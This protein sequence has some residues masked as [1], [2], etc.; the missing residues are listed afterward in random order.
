MGLPRV[1]AAERAADIPAAVAPAAPTVGRWLARRKGRLI[2]LGLVIVAAVL[3]VFASSAGTR[4]QVVRA[5]RRSLVQRVVATGRVEPKARITIG[6]L[7]AGTVARVGPEE[8]DHVKA[9]ELLVELDAVEARAAVDQ[10]QAG[11]ALAQAR[12]VQ[13]RGTGVKLA[14]ESLRQAELSL[15]NAQQGLKRTES[16]YASGASAEKELDDARHK[17]ELAASQ[18]DSA[19]L[20]AAS[21]SPGGG[22]VLM[23]QANLAQSQAMLAQAK[24]RLEQLRLTAPVDALVLSRQVEKGDMV[25]PGRALYTLAKDGKT[26]L[27]AQPDEKSLAFLATGQSALASADAFP[28]QTFLATVAAIAPAVDP[29]RGTVEVKFDVP[30]PPAYLRADMTVSV[31]VQVSRVEG[32]LV[33]PA[34]TVQ[35]AAGK[36]SWVWV[37]EDEHAARRTVKLGVKGEGSVQILEGLSEGEAVITPDGKPLAAGQKVRA[38]ARPAEPKA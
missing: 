24:A 5:A 29:L 8:G 30:E 31:D 32:A 21:A 37:V 23:A 10:A 6:S 33:V 3:A 4:V 19:V 28:A 1:E 9:G 34:E 22:A 13:L 20:S 26:R 7:A 35:E 15:A 11:V 16:L 38:V 27:A 25:Q 14:S 18:R 12:L 17:A 36:K 2:A